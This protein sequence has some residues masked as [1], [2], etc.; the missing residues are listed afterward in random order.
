MKASELATIREPLTR[1]LQAHKFIRAMED[2]R[3]V[4]LFI[5]DRALLDIRAEDNPLSFAKIGEPLGLTRNR[6]IQMYQEAEK[7]QNNSTFP[8]YTKWEQEH[9]QEDRYND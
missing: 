1:F 4:A 3:E 8:D 6:I 5:R 2:S 9:E 7:R